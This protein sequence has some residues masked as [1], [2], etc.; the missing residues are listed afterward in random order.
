MKLSK[1]HLLLAFLLLLGLQLGA[2]SSIENFTSLKSQGAMPADFQ[3]ITNSD[4]ELYDYNVFLKRMVMDGR[5]LYGTPLNDYVNT[6]ADNLLKDDL[7]LRSKIHI[8][9]AKSPVVNAY[10]T[11]NGIIIVNLGMLA[12]VSNESELAFILAHEITH[13][14]EKHALQYQDYKDTLSDKDYLNY[15]VKTQ[16]RSRQQEL[17]ADRI[18]LNRYFYK[19]NYSYEIMDGVFDV[20]Q[21]SD[22]PFDEVPF[23]KSLVETDFYQFPTNYYLTNVAPI[24]NRAD[25]VDTLF[26]H[27]NIEKRRIAVHALLV[28]KSNDGRSTFVQSEQLFNEIRELARFECI[29][30][31][32]TE[33]QFDHAFYNTYVLLQNHPDNKFLNE[34]LAE[35]VYGLSKFRNYGSINNVITSYKKVEGEMQQT[36]HFLSKLTR[37]EASLLALRLAWKAKEKDPNNTHLNDILQDAMKDVFIKNKMKYQDF[38]DFPMGTDPDTIKLEDTTTTSATTNKYDRIKQQNKKALVL[39]SEKFKTQNYMLVD[40]HQNDDFIA[41]MNAIINQDED[42]KILDIVTRKEPVRISRM[43]IAEPQYVVSNGKNILNK[44]SEKEAQRVSKNLSTCLR[45]LKID[46]ISFSAKDV[47]GFS[48]EQYNGYAELQQ[49]LHEYEQAEG[50]QMFYHNSKDMTGA[51]DLTG[52]TKVCQA[53]IKRT[54]GNFVSIDKTNALALSAFCPYTFPFSV[55]IFAIPRYSTEMYLVVTDF[56]TGITEIACHD[57]K[58][59]AMKDAYVNSFLYDQ[60]YKFVKG[61]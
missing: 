35:A 21:Y 34:S 27:P 45:K 9:I 53:S 57:S 41:I 2:Q 25:M 61:K 52:T 32:L 42:D 10:A 11:L 16:T 3:K 24:T 47:I 4:K 28:G 54:P 48:T 19:T 37:Q 6:I 56:Q 50:M 17:E 59:S 23:P 31:F 5:I 14:A 36:C 1:T 8:Y 20:L 58:I 7:V 43:L 26:T 33:Q 55:A 18:A 38:C 44:A 30:Y 12:Q 51:Y 13:V 40:L 29:N 22:L 46:A 49:W 39:P 15:Y 60:L